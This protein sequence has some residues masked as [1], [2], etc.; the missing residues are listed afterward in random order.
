MY[1]SLKVIILLKLIN[2]KLGNIICKYYL[3]C[4]LT[5]GEFLAQIKCL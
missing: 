2:D 3:K 1:I 5:I 4:Y